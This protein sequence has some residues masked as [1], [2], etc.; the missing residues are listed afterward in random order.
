MGQQQQH[1]K[2][3]TS[4]SASVKKQRSVACVTTTLRKKWVTLD[5]KLE[6]TRKQQFLRGI[7]QAILLSLYYIIL[8]ASRDLWI[9]EMV[10]R[11][12]ILA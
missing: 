6:R 3:G 2:T 4:S 1:F 7:V 5:L 12:F 9:K 10:P 11:L 8:S